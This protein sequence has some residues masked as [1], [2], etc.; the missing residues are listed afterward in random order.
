[1]A[2][3]EKVKKVKT[4][5]KVPK[6]VVSPNGMVEVTATEKSRYIKAGTK[7]EVTEAMAEIL[8]KKGWFK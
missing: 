5:V 6:K 2:T 8:I 1:M 3:K 7:K 4:E